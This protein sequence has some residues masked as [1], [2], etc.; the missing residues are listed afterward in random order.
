VT[1]RGFFSVALL[2]PVVGAL[3]GLTVPG[4]RILTMAMAFGGVPYVVFAIVLAFLVQG[5]STRRA[6]VKLSLLAP[7]CFALLVAAFVDILGSTSAT[8]QLS[9]RETAL[10]LLPIAAYALAFSYIYIACAWSLWALARK[11]GVVSD[12]FAAT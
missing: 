9:I 4:L 10:Q 5:A 2:L 3:L 11:V 6:L 8:R 12:E 1:T 7:L